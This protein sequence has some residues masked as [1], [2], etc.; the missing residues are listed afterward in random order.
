[1]GW[2]RLHPQPAA[3]LSSKPGGVCSSPFLPEQLLILLQSVEHIHRGGLLKTICLKGW[4]HV[5][6]FQEYF[7]DA[8][9]HQVII[10]L[11][12]SPAQLAQERHS[13]GLSVEQG[14]AC[15]AWPHRQ[16]RA[17]LQ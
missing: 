12:E 7:S 15:T 4:Q 10:P 6:K 3:F 14:A 13:H 1:M 9:G 17:K 5:Y 8:H 16:P 2:Q 11:Q